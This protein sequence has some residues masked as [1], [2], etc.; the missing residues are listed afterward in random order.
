M[1]IFYKL[2]LHGSYCM[3]YQF[4]RKIE[5]K[6]TLIRCEYIPYGLAGLLIAKLTCYSCSG[7]FVLFI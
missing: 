6:Q 1:I 3:F 7:S 5:H 4:N 2:L